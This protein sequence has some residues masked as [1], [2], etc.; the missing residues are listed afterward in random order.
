MQDAAES[1][2]QF[3]GDRM[4]RIFLHGLESS[5][6]GAKASFLR[7][8]FPD[9]LIPDFRGSLSER[10]VSL[11]AILAGRENIVIA[12]S[13]FGGLMGTLF[14][15]EKP[16][17]VDRLVLL[18]PALNFPEFS[19]YT[20]KYIGVPT[21]III[22]KD[23]TVTP[24]REVLPLARKIFTDLNYNEVDDNH[25][26]AQTFRKFDWQTLLAE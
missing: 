19:Q 3:L 9:M 1:N 24:V 5:S 25:M 10:M 12:G 8:L 18:A 16:E 13:S 6:K 2:I 26:L 17:A 20:R 15:M 14:A 4:V 23:D 7:A 21:W 11:K 22:G